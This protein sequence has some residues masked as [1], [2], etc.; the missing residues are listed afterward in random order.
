MNHTDHNNND[1][2]GGGGPEHD[3]GHAAGS[4]GG[5]HGTKR[6][7]PF[8]SWFYFR[9][10]YSMYFV[11]VLGVLNTL[12]LT[13]YLTIDNYPAL[14]SV[15]P[16]FTTYIVM[17]VM[18][19]VPVVVLLGYVHMRRS[20]AYRSDVE[21]STETNP[22]MYKLPPG[23]HREVMAPFFYEVL[24]ALKKADAGQDLSPE[25]VQNI[26]DLDKKLEFLVG[27]GVLKRPDAFGG[28]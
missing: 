7:V 18:V 12:T 10:G 28:L 9:T 20:S 8:R 21:V 14:E 24:G 3:Y 5:S 23:I 27:G 19:G 13:Y 2:G 6:S 15:F 22:Y 1:D 11:F 26:K 16:T 4:G 17:M 25:E